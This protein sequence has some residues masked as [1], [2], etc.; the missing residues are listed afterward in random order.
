MKIN[1]LCKNKDR[2]VESLY[3]IL[4]LSE[5]NKKDASQVMENLKVSRDI[6]KEV[7]EKFD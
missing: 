7:M 1:N 4:K 6:Q 2:T 5:H 3:N